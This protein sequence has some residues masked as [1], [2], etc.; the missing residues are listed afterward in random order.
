[1]FEPGESYRNTKSED[2]DDIFVLGIGAENET[3]I[4]IAILRIDRETKDTKESGELRV[5]KE[6][7]KYW[8]KLEINE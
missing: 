4:W 7:Y 1:M 6:E 2:A 3:E 5:P 8:R